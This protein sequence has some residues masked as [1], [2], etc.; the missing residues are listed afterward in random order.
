MGPDILADRVASSLR[1]RPGVPDPCTAAPSICTMPRADEAARGVGAQPQ[2]LQVLPF[3]LSLPC[4]SPNSASFSLLPLISPET[5]KEAAPRPLSQKLLTSE[6][7][8]RISFY[9]CSVHFYSERGALR[10]QS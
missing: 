7:Y 9:R 3:S 1:A 10:T 5:F 8:K 4:S 6:K 2:T